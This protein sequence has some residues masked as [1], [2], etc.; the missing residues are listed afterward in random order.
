MSK[1]KTSSSLPSSEKHSRAVRAALLDCEIECW[2]LIS[3][4]RQ[5]RAL[6]LREELAL[7]KLDLILWSAASTLPRA[8]AKGFGDP[9]APHRTARDG[10]NG[11]AA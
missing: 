1:V 3:T 9:A 4:L 2:R 11:S 7:R 10:S 8:P 5:L 6:L